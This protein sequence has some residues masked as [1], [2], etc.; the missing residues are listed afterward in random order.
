MRML[1]TSSLAG[2]LVLH[3][4]CG[5]TRIGLDLVWAGMLLLQAAVACMKKK[6]QALQEKAAAA[7]GDEGEEG[8][9]SDREADCMGRWWGHLSDTAGDARARSHLM[10]TCFSF[11]TGQPPVCCARPRTPVS[12]APFPCPRAPSVPG[13]PHLC[14]RPLPHPT[15]PRA[16]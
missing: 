9:L 5:C 3:M 11:L 16:G 13:C 1:A 15:L 14:A 8:K 7:E 2:G 4:L 12:R 6:Q 10:S